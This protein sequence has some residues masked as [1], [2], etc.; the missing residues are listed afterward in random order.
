MQP[1]LDAVAILNALE[2]AE[3]HLI[4][5]VGIDGV[6]PA[7]A[8]DYPFIFRLLFNDNLR[9][10]G[11]G[12]AQ[13]S[14]RKQLGF[15]T[16]ALRH[17]L[18]DRQSDRISPRGL[19]FLA[20]STGRKSRGKGGWTD[21]IV[22]AVADSPALADRS[23]S[24]LHLELPAFS[25]YRTPKSTR[26]RYIGLEEIGFRIR[27]R[28][29]TPDLGLYG[30]DLRC[31]REAAAEQGLHVAALESRAVRQSLNY[32]SRRADA[33]RHDLIRVRPELVLTYPWYGSVNMCLM[34]AANGLG[35]PAV[36]V[37]HGVQGP[38]HAAYRRWPSFAAG[39]DLIPSDFWVWREADKMWLESW[40]PDSK[41]S[42]VTGVIWHGAREV[43]TDLSPGVS[44]VLERLD[45]A[46]KAGKQV[47]LVTLQPFPAEFMKWLKGVLAEAPSND[48]V[49]AIRNHPGYRSGLREIA[50]AL[51]GVPNVLPV[52]DVMIA[53]LASLLRRSHAH[54]THYS[55]VVQEAALLGVPS[56]FTANSSELY[57][58]EVES[59]LAY[60]V[61][62]A[63][64]FWRSFRA[65]SRHVSA[66]AREVRIGA[67]LS[68]ALDEAMC[69]DMNRK[70]G[71]PALQERDN[72]GN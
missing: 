10:R 42:T 55:S 15:L 24:A 54:V 27:Q 51:E 19:L 12:Q 5:K 29:G 46:S 58:A 71:H 72:L 50:D 47:I 25:D 67:A 2:R 44:T 62:D 70:D 21:P 13:G 59:G 68:A 9:R 52:E 7:F 38:L 30:Q 65:A 23:M 26:S 35:I 20:P 3:L 69:R 14:A 63:A 41:R 16:Q 34:R 18:L 11:L 60:P 33:F 17:E 57:S 49:W 6:N 43:A 4:A 37:Q 28:F 40:L 1:Q 22:S 45:E 66:E 48:F 36:D 61:V 53:P 56:F 39:S 64:D 31:F 32:L 8:R